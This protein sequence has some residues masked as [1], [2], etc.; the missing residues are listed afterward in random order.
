MK[1]LFIT[2]LS[3]VSICVLAQSPESGKNWLLPDAGIEMVFVKDGTF[4][5]GSD[6]GAVDEKPVHKVVISKPFWIGKFE[7]T[8]G[9]FKKITGASP[10]FNQG[11]NIP[12]EQVSWNDAVAFCEKI[13][14]AEKKGGRL[15][16]G[17]EYRLPTEAEWEFAAR[18]GDKN[19][20]PGKLDEAAWFDK[21][22]EGKTHEVG[23]KAPNANGLFDS[24]GNV[25][26]WC[27]DSC[28]FNDDGVKTDTY[29]DSSD[30]LSQK[31]DY[32]VHRGGSWCYTE[33][34]C[35]YSSRYANKPD[36]SGGDI[37]FRIVLA[38][39]LKK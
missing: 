3:F 28:D 24:L 1:S 12:V 4:N 31:G 9:Q 11:E 32:K 6:K 35:H 26:E 22:S 27:L 14:I 8:Q 30:P 33:K 2:V 23:K 25:W 37:G 39:A 38:P 10:A 34:F 7:V 18:A 17:Y 29:R 21:T 20:V 16:E 19:D 36:F 13:N 5:M 15:P